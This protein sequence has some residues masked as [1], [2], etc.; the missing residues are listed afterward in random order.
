MYNSGD[1]TPGVFNRTKH[2][3]YMYKIHNQTWEVYVELRYSCECL[4]PIKSACVINA[5]I[6]CGKPASSVVVYSTYR[7]L[8][9]WSWNAVSHKTESATTAPAEVVVLT[10]YELPRDPRWQLEE[11]G[12]ATG[13]PESLGWRSGP[14]RRR[15]CGYKV[16]TP[17]TEGP[18]AKRLLSPPLKGSIT[19]AMR[20]NC[21]K[22]ASPLTNRQISLQHAFM[23][24]SIQHE[25]FSTLSPR[26][27]RR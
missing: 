24:S 20:M 16:P 13:K 5:N 15:G 10:E 7:A 1:D 11:R 25:T 27:S 18:C 3:E 9:A 23:S 12:V 8:E 26:F 22:S 6:N 21:V 19:A 17:V 2:S 4:C 14:E